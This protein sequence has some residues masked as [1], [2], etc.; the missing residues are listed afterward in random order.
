[1]ILDDTAH[2]DVT[3]LLDG[4][5]LR[6]TVDTGST[7]SVMRLQAAQSIFGLDEKSADMNA[8]EGSKGQ[9]YRHP[10]HSLT[11]GD[12]Q[13]VNPDIVIMPDRR[14][15]RASSKP[16]ILGMGILR[17]L[18]IYLAYREQAI[19]ATAAEAR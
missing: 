14:M 1:M 2:I 9:E 18:H 11:V 16:L 8:I 5:D 6:A 19:Y 7:R 12:I 15:G 3:V 17:Q 4:K 13:V 10:F